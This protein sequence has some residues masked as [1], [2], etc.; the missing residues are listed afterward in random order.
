MKIEPE[1]TSEDV[2]LE[3]LMIPGRMIKYALTLTESTT[4]KPESVLGWQMKETEKGP[5]Y[6]RTTVQITACG[7]AEV[8][9]SGTKGT[10]DY[11]QTAHV[12]CDE[13]DKLPID[14]SDL[15]AGCWTSA[16]DGNYYDKDCKTLEG[17]DFKLPLHWK[18]QDGGSAK[19]DK[20]ASSAKQYA[21]YRGHW[22][23]ES[24]DSKACLSA[25]EGITER[26]VHQDGTVSRRAKIRLLNPF[27]RDF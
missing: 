8:T 14:L 21:R 10:K 15:I 27:N 12:T 6:E 16:E 9:E 5:V 1:V 25:I 26:E 11:K 7:V 22:C 24:S 13:H 19:T 20:G 18:H 17:K 23:T 2:T 4:E 3:G